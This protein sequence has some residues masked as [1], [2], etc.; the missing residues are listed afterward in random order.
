MQVL[1]NV[2]INMYT[3]IGQ[4]YLGYLL[5]SS[6]LV[7]KSSQAFCNN[8]KC[9]WLGFL[10]RESQKSGFTGSF[11]ATD[12]AL[13]SWVKSSEFFFFCNFG[14]LPGVDLQGL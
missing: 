12:L 9:A 3:R 4:L 6:F 11:T 14:F 10:H 7:K 2:L 1:E 8:M 13:G 5:P